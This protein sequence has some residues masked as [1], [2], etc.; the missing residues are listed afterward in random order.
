MLVR[1]GSRVTGKVKVRV[2]GK[3]VKRVTLR[4]GRA[5]VRI[6]IGKVGKHTIIAAYLGSAT[7]ARST[8]KARVIRVR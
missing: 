4:K 6:R 2:D 3:V 1:A 8:S 7:V 5:V